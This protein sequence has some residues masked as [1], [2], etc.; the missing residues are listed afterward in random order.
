MK[1][2]TIRVANATAAVRIDDTGAVETG[3]A[4]VGALLAEHDWQTIAADADGVRHDPTLLDFAP[5]VPHPNKIVC[6]GLNYRS[7]ILE[8]GRELPSYPT[9]FAKFADTLIGARD[10]IAMPSASTALDWEAELAVVVGSSVRHANRATAE[11]AIAGYC[12]LNDITARDWQYRTVEWLQG[13]N[14]ESTTPLGPYLLTADAFDIAAATIEGRVGEEV[15]QSAALNDLLFDPADLVAYLST[16]ITLRPGDV[17]ATGTPGGV[18]HAREPR[19]Y[20]TPGA[21]VTT[22]ITGLGQC[23]N[24]CQPERVHAA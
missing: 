7:H 16:I 6:V 1:L 21:I 23:R 3:H 11:A 2:A 24:V 14:F 17:I 15:V 9:L 10:E 12:V 5:V 8:M 20:L 19:R 4:D 22:S 13:K 18:G